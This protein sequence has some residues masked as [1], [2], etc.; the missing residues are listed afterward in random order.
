MKRTL[1]LLLH[2][3]APILFGAVLYYLLCPHVWFVERLKE[4]ISQGAFRFRGENASWM[5]AGADRASGTRRWAEVFLATIP[6][7]FVRNYLFDF[8]WGYSLAAGIM[9]ILGGEIKQGRIIGLVCFF[10]LFMECLQLFPQVEGTFDFWDV[11]TEIA[12]G[13]L[14]LIIYQKFIITEGTDEKI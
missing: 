1:R 13:Y 11:I 12:A 14:F 6:G 2:M 8:L 9:W 4:L 5:I 10:S 7:R 3:A